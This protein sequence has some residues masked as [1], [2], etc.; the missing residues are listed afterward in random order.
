[1]IHLETQ[2]CCATFTALI[3]TE[4]KPQNMPFFWQKLLLSISWPFQ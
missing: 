2:H 3:H 1:V 4:N